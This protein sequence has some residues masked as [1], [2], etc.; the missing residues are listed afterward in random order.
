MTA[1]D[2]RISGELCIEPA[3]PTDAALLHG[4]AE[5]CFSSPWSEVT[6]ASMLGECGCAFYIARSGGS[7]VGFCA[8]RA[9]SDEGELLD[10]A[11]LPEHRRGGIGT[12]LLGA[13]LAYLRDAGTERIFLEVRV[14]NSA[15]QSMYASCG[16][17]ACGVRKIRLTG[18]EPLVRRPRMR[19]SWCSIFRTSGTVHR[20]ELLLFITCDSSEHA[21]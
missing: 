18:G 5:R 19:R 1:A 16:F 8:V 21:A 4:I 9:A 6:F 3:A 15:A 17:T 2:L 10:I 12:A 20:A 14:S 7:A 11:V 13:G